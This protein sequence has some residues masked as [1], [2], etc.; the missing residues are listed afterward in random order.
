MFSLILGVALSRYVPPSGPRR[1]MLPAG[2]R[3]PPGAAQAVH[4]PSMSPE[5]PS[6]TDL[7]R[8]IDRIDEAL[9]DLLMRRAE[10][11]DRIR[12]VKRGATEGYFRPAREAQVLRR[13]VARHAGPLPRALIV[14]L[15]RELMSALVAMQGPFAVAVWD[16]CGDGSLWD[17][18]RDHFGALAPMTRHQTA[19]GVIHAVSHGE[20]TVGVLPLPEDGE[21]DPWWPALMGAHVPPPLRICGRLPF[22]VGDQG[23]RPGLRHAAAASTVQV[24]GAALVVGNVP[25]EPSGDDLSFLIVESPA[26]VSRASLTTAL[27]SVGLPAV[28]LA[29]CEGVRDAPT[30]YLVEVEGFVGAD[31]TRLVALAADARTVGRSRAVGGYARPLAV[32]AAETGGWRREGRP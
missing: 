22:A 13:L 26:G 6:L 24:G 14:R 27:G 16:G 29:A 19:R 18:A 28:A 11:V 23:R 21:A 5:S 32:G 8:E 31:D 4:D 10:V 2:H 15:W 12:L 25:F 3:L 30:L 20:A 1:N 17:L 7:R 9:H